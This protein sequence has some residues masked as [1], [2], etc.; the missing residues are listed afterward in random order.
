MPKKGG[1]IKTN[2]FLDPNKI[3]EVNVTIKNGNKNFS[4]IKTPLDLFEKKT[5]ITWR[6]INNKLII[7][8]PL[9]VIK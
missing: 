7:E 5:L 8:R 4:I 1:K 3:I 2:L 6:L 9:I